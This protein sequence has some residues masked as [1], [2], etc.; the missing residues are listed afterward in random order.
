[1]LLNPVMVWIQA[2]PGASIAPLRGM[3]F[4]RRFLTL[5]VPPCGTLSPRHRTPPRR[6]DGANLAVKL[7]LADSVPAD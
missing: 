3:M 6:F 1:M 7:T 4:H 5:C 2:V